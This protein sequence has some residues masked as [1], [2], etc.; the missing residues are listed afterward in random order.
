MSDVSCNGFTDGSVQ[1]TVSDFSSTYSYT[2]NA[3]TAVTGQSGA[4][5]NE[6]S[7][8]AGTYTIVVTDEVTGCTATTAVTVTEPANP[9]SIDSAT[10]TNV[11][12]N[13]D[14]S[15][16]TVTASGG[17]PSYTY[18]AVVSGASAPLAGAYSSGNVVTVDTN[19]ATD[20]VWD[21][22]VRDANGC[23]ETTTVT[24][25]SDGL[26]T[27]NAVTPQ[28]YEGSDLTFTLVGT[29]TVGT[30]E[31]SMGSGFQAS[32][33]FTVTGPGT[34]T[35]TIRDGNGCTADQTLVVEPQVQLSAVLTLSLIHI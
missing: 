7:L 23:T 31:Y 15:Q 11:F 20:L 5:I 26:P 19:S 35:F 27:L 33:T 28:C 13:E 14:T 2:I 6:T 12:C 17:T 16:I 22:Y 9:L 25:T 21:V 4:T 18:A 24:V 10:A 3:G 8:A 1:F 32:P 29:V 34:Y 30:A